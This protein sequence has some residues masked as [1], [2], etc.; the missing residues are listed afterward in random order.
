M[1][2]GFLRDEKKVT[3]LLAAAQTKTPGVDASEIRTRRAALQARKDELAAL[4]TE[5]VL[6]GPAVR[7]EA[8]KLTD[9][10][11]ALDSALADLARRSPLAELLS[12]GVEQVDKRWGEASQD[13]RGKVIDELFTVVIKPVPK[14]HRAAGFNPDYVDI[15]WNQR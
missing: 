9:K 15:V 8:A 6:D 14:G 2:V 13:I 11:A 3:A 1:A 4:F 10:I 5:G 12:E 7:R